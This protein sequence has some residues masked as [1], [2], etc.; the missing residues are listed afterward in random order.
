MSIQLSEADQKAVPSNTRENASWRWKKAM[1]GV[2]FVSPQAIGLAVFMA[3]PIA[4]SGV[5]SLF[6]WPMLGG[7]R[8]FIGLTNYRKLFASPFFIHALGNTIL[9][10]ALYLT[11]NLIVSLAIAAWLSGPRVRH[12]QFFRVLF[13]LPT[14]TPMVANVV[15]W[16]LLYQPNGA[17]NATVETIF[18]I[19]G[20]DYLNDPRWAMIAIVIMSVWQGFGYNMLIFSSA[21]DNVPTDV[22]HAAEID[23]ANRWVL[24][25]KVKL[26]LI[27][28][29]VFFASTMTMITS[30]Q[31]FTQPF[32][33]TKGGPG[34]STMTLVYYIYNQG[35]VYQDLGF[36]AA[37]A[38]LMFMI[39]VTITVIQFIGEKKWVFY[40]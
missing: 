7:E 38:W 39:I 13:F 1:A 20:P 36:A 3:I 2:A 6:D 21:L 27:S 4:M 23:G 25:F 37:A 16:K 34:D 15:V 28:P 35:F 29:S 22:V 9:Y 30:F 33:L 19:D 40:D 12:R 26:P 5:M 11:L 32:I 14:V 31:L 8:T 17:I 18:R 24:F 10:V